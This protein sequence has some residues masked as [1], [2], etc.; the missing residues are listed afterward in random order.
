MLVGTKVVVLYWPCTVLEDLVEFW[1]GLS[2]FRR[3]VR[4]EADFAVFAPF[5][6]IL[7]GASVA[8]K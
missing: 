1:Y 5:K 3:S 8:E 7:L 6:D 4:R 2:D